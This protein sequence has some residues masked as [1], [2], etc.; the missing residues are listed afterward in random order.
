ME[1]QQILELV[2]RWLHMF[3]SAGLLGGMLFMRFGLWPSLAGVGAE[4]RGRIF[5]GAARKFAPWIG[6]FAVCVLLSGI[7]NMVGAANYEFPGKFYNPVVGV[8]LLLGLGVIGLFSVLC[9]RTA[10]AEKLRKNASTWLD[11]CLILTIAL[12]MMGGLLR[13]A[14]LGKVLKKPIAASETP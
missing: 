10:S 12:V 2:L 14:S 9:G 11:L 8:K 5:G 1:P 7:Y 6:I 13:V 3:G 4:E